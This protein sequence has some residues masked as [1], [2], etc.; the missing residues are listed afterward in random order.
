MV[1]ELMG[2]L[3]RKMEGLGALHTKRLMVKGQG[4]VKRRAL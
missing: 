2:D 1:E 4:C 3:D